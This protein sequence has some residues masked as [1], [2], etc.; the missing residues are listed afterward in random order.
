MLTQVC[1]APGVH[2]PNL[3]PIICAVCL[4]FPSELT[5]AKPQVAGHIILLFQILPQGGFDTSRSGSA[6]GGQIQCVGTTSCTQVC[7]GA[8][9]FGR[10]VILC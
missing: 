3:S 4:F 10:A 9:W 5:R 6:S 8:F 1:A 2:L 7:C